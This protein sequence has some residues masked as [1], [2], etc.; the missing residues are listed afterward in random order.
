MC[1]FP[2]GCLWVI[3]QPSRDVNVGNTKKTLKGKC[4][5]YNM[6]INTFWA[7]YG[8]R[9]SRR[10]AFL[11]FLQ[12]VRGGALWCSMWYSSR[13]L[14]WRIRSYAYIWQN[15]CYVLYCQRMRCFGSWRYQAAC[16]AV[17][18]FLSRYV[19]WFRLGN[20][21]NGIRQRGLVAR[22]IVTIAAV[23]FLWAL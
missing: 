16:L 3:I 21:G 22:T 19:Y 17:L 13:N 15:R 11:A 18:D 23:I 9:G 10:R 5:H 20:A 12:L 4:H 14:N 6:A 7:R 8:R 1:G 2:V